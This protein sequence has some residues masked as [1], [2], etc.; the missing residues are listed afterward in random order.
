M[1]VAGQFSALP[2]ESLIGGPL[3]A[4]ATAQGTLANITSDFITTVG[5]EKD[6]DK[7]KAR[8][9]AFNYQKPVKNTTTDK[10]GNTTETWEKQ[11][12]SLD[13]PLLSI[14]KSPNLQVKEVDINFNMEVKASSAS[15]NENSQKASV[16]ASWSGWGAKVKFHGSVSNKNTSQRSSDTSAKYE[17]KVLAKDDGAPEGLMKVLDILGEA[18]QPADGSSAPSK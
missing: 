10:D 3:Q 14:V 6:G 8:T 17:V 15:T 16:D 5:L 2:M 1:S 12:M 9:V 18:I 7:L 13:V 4:A 11:E